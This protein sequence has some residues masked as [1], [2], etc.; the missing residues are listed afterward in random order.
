MH[1][2]DQRPVQRLLRPWA[3]MAAAVPPQ[4]A[5]TQE[6]LLLSPQLDYSSSSKNRA[7]VSRMRLRP[8]EIGLWL[9]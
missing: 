6:A 2:A 1:S 5:P 8:L 3:E 7:A 4:A 9:R